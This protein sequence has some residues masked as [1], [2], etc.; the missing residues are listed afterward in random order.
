MSSRFKLQV[1][2]C[3]FTLVEGVIVGS[4]SLLVLAALSTVF[5]LNTIQ[6]SDGAV[7]TLAQMQYANVVDQIGRTVRRA[8]SASEVN[9]VP[10]DSTLNPPD[11]SPSPVM[12][13]FDRSGNLIGGFQRSGTALQEWSGTQFINFKAGGQNVQVTSG[14]N[15]AISGGRKNVTVN[16]SVFAA[17]GAVKDTVA[18]KKESFSCRN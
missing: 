10:V 9:P 8:S 18:S 2:N 6:T 12:Y 11:P 4:L 5:Y 3:G 7:N 13:L 1:G 15:F 16:L 14:S 17:G